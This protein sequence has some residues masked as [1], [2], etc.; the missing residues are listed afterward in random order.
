M[1]QHTESEQ[2]YQPD[3]RSFSGSSHTTSQSHS[4][5]GC[6]E[7]RGIPG[8]RSRAPA[9]SMLTSA[10]QRTASQLLLHLTFNLRQ[11]KPARSIAAFGVSSMTNCSCSVVCAGCSQLLLPSPDY[12]HEP[13]K[14]P[15]HLTH[16]SEFHSRQVSEIHCCEDNSFF[17]SVFRWGRK[18][19]RRRAS[20]GQNAV[21]FHTISFYWLTIDWTLSLPVI[22]L[23]SSFQGINSFVNITYWQQ[24]IKMNCKGLARQQCSS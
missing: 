20:T 12:L 11:Q 19:Y 24:S 7:W 6:S 13:H 4:S 16:S 5:H 10:A 15:T 3:S 9:A 23:P 14:Q 17:G 2:E 18:G 1:K 21:H 22:F 8:P